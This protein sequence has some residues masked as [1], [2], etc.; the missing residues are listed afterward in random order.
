MYMKKLVVLL[1]LLSLCGCSS[2]KNKDEADYLRYKDNLLLIDNA[3]AFVESSDY[4]DATLEVTNNVNGFSYYLIIDNPRYAM[5]NVSVVAVIEGVTYDEN[6]MAPNYGIFG[7]ERLNLIPNQ[8][9]IEGGYVKGVV[10]NG[11]TNNDDFVLKVL[12]SWTN[13]NNDKTHYEYLIIPS[14]EGMSIEGNYE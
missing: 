7:E 4:F 5:Y 14:K 2:K 10:V 11:V 1:V 12:V 8:L 9:Y 13:E 6:T 3:P